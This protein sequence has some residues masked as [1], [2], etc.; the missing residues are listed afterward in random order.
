MDS[1]KIDLSGDGK[2]VKEIKTQ[3]TGE[4]PS[5]GNKV[6]GNDNSLSFYGNEISNSSLHWNFDQRKEI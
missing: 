1:T 5:K 3:G 2:L 6:K 4:K